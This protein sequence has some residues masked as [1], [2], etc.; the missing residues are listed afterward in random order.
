MGHEHRNLD[1]IVLSVASGIC[2]ALNGAFAKLTT[3]ELTSSLATVLASWIS[4]ESFPSL[5]EAFVRV[6]FALNLI[7]NGIMWTLF[8]KALARGTSTTQVS[9]LNT[10]SNFMITGM[11]G[12]VI[13]SEKLSPTWLIGAL[14]LITG[15]VIIGHRGESHD[16]IDGVSKPSSSSS[17][18]YDL[19][20]N[21]E[22]GLDDDM[23]NTTDCEVERDSTHLDSQDK[24]ENAKII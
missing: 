1:W 14:L 23:D 13:F 19:L 20:M 7:F 3:T 15:S 2:A 16:D 4:L 24:S 18:E 10:S 22:L 11:L 21:D 8:T 12:W 6:F 5:V 17:E 9:I